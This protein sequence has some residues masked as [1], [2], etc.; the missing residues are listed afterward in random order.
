MAQDFTATITHPER[1]AEWQRVLGTTTV[2]IT[3]PIPIRAN[4]PGHPNAEI[5]LLDL[6]LI[7]SQQ[8][9]ALITHLAARFNLP[10][11]E[12]ESDLDK[13]GVPILAQDC[14]VAVANPH[15]WFCD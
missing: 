3:T 9:E 6:N 11:Q 5:Y 1:A 7:S 13:H 10:R 14:I 12:V 2:Y 4:L 15:K 8:R